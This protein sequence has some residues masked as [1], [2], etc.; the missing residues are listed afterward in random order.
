MKGGARILGAAAVIVFGFNEN[1]V[2][3]YKNIGVLLNFS[4]GAWFRSLGD[5]VAPSREQQRKRSLTALSAT[6]SIFGFLTSS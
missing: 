3:P 4:F 5:D 1:E 2:G 6:N